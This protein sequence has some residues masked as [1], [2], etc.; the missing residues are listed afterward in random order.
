MRN[1]QPLGSVVP[2]LRP[3]VSWSPSLF[4]GKPSVVQITQADWFG[5]LDEMFFA[6][7][8]MSTLALPLASWPVITLRMFNAILVSFSWRAPAARAP[9][10]VT[11]LAGGG[12]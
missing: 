1:T 11:L 9:G 6:T 5:R 12:A 2:T 7:S 8:S 4:T 10:G 3:D